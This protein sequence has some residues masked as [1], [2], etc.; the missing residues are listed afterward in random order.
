MP[1]DKQPTIG[2]RPPSDLMD[3]LKK[4]AADNARSLNGQVVWALQQFRQQQE[5]ERAKA[6]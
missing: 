6:S 2:L 1:E 3:W 5:V 4:E